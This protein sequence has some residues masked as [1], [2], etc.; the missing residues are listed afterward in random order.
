MVRC[1][2]D[3]NPMHIEPPK[4]Q[5][6]NPPRGVIIYYNYYKPDQQEHPRSAGY[7]AV[8]LTQYRFCTYHILTFAKST[9]NPPKSAYLRRSNRSNTSPIHGAINNSMHGA[10]HGAPFHCS[11]H[12]SHH[13]QHQWPGRQLLLPNSQQITAGTSP[14]SSNFN[15]GAIFNAGACSRS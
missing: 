7:L 11:I 13:H 6:C 14:T 1:C 2:V 4:I 3:G 12:H 8:S 10:P 15:P 9:S 5:I